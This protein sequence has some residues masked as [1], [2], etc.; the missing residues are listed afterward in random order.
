MN[1]LLLLLFTLILFFEG[2]A[3]TRVVLNPS[4]AEQSHREMSIDKIKFYPDST[5][6]ELIII[7][8]LPEGGWFC[9]DS[10]TYIEDAKG[11]ARKK[12]YNVHGISWCPQVYRFQQVGETLQISLVFPEMAVETE[13]L[14]LF[15]QCE[16]ACFSFRGIILDDKLNNDIR[17]FDEAMNCYVSNKLD[18]AIELFM[19]IIE[20]IPANPTHV[21]G[22]SYYHLVQIYLNKGDKKTAHFWFEQLERSG[23]PNRQYYLDAIRQVLESKY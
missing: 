15:E 2:N 13:V 5:V 23:L 9:I 17:L 7:N 12:V 22:Y 20:D 6:I 4:V 16:R 14:N 10:N 21:Y 3:Q 19:N 11:L 1:R 18:Q 8:N